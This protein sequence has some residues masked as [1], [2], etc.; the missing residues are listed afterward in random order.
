[1]RKLY[2]IGLMACGLSACKPNIEPNAP[3][4]GDAD[5]SRYMAVG[6]SLTAG[7]TNGSLYRDGQMHSYPR[8]LADQ[9]GTVG[10]GEFRQPLLPGEHGWPWAKKILDYVT[11]PCD[12]VATL[13]PTDFKGALDTFTSSNN[14]YDIGPFNNMGIP[15]IRVIDFLVPGYGMFNPYATR[16]FKTPATSRPIDELL[17]VEHT[18]FTLW[19][20]NNDVL[21]YAQAGG[22][23]GATVPGGIGK[24]TQAFEFATA[25]DSVMDALTRSGAKGVVLNIPDLLSAPYF[26]TIPAKGLT[27]DKEKANLLN[28]NYNGTQVH[29][30]VGANYF[31]IQDNKA[32]GGFRQIKDGELIRLELPMD[33]VKCAGWGT[34]KPIPGSYVLTME[35]V[36]KANKFIAEYNKIIN[37]M[38][39]KYNIPVVDIAAYLRAAQ[40]G[41]VYNGVGFTTTYVQGGV[42]SLDGLHM[43]GRGY[44]LVANHIL[45]KINEHYGST[46]PMV[47]VNAHPGI[48]F[49]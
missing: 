7:Y 3:E 49:P 23:E 4:R 8:M 39:T 11:G 32:P 6:N 25:Y 12:T 9:F 34:I 41:V 42:F 46:I 37:Q 33:S 13:Q 45:M 18:F 22:E 10:G 28:L 17:N 26:T 48:M 40:T 1:M 21:G 16:M 38:A 14:I 20:G 43:T 44:A 30:D 27:L 35:E 19:L 5:F 29:F 15:G 47:D 36:D 2:I 24:L 31:V